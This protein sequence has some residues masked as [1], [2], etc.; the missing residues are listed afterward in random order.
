MTDAS[1]N[2]AFFG[3]SNGS[4]TLTPSR[5]GYDFSPMSL[6]PSVNDAD[7]TGVSFAS[8]MR[9]YGIS[10]TVSGDTVADVVITLSG[11]G[12]GTAMT[13]ASGH[14][15]FTGLSNGSYTLTPSKA[16]Y[17]FSPGSLSPAV[18]GADVT[19]QNF[20]AALRTFSI[21]GTVSGDTASG[22]LVTL[23]G[24]ADRTEMTDASGNYAFTGLS[25][26]DYELTPS[27]AGYAFSPTSLRPTVNG[28]NV[29]G[30]TLTATAV[31]TISGTV[32][33]DTAAGVTMTLTGAYVRTETTDASGNYTFTG[34]R[35][36][37]YTLTPSKDGYMFSPPS[38][39]PTV[40]GADVASQD[41]AAIQMLYRI[42][43]NVEVGVA[44]P[45]SVYLSGD[46][47]SIAFAGSN[48]DYAFSGLPNGSYVVTPADATVQPISQSVT[49][50]NATV[51]GV[52]FAYVNAHWTNWSLPEISPPNA[53]YD[54]GAVAGTVTDLVTGLVWQREVPA[55]TY[56]N[57]QAHGY[58]RALSLGGWSTG[59]RLP[60]AIELESIVDYGMWGPAINQTAFPGTTGQYFWTGTWGSSGSYYWAVDFL[61]GGA[62]T[63]SSSTPFRV[64]CVRG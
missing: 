40:S 46:R 52:D 20:G 4:Y 56:T 11:A 22:V 25:N 18:N 28:S 35:N 64:R 61:Y 55:G 29:T 57:S 15:A 2:F 60:T 38:L 32:S 47:T 50:A 37:D 48:G 12:S 45:A 21:S 6:S 5:A 43:G 31:F 27:K 10:G 39:S 30:Q 63:Y 44:G 26:G 19:G 3:L 36:G 58:C 16:G 33:G 42:E 1:G 54:T 7:V 17:D 24:A 62:A 59:W 51:T 13:D 14:Y 8:T 34:V 9:T 49:I 53:D 41:F 23:S